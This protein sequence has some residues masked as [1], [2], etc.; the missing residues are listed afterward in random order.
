MAGKLRSGLLGAG[1]LASVSASGITLVWYFTLS[2]LA[3]VEDLPGDRVLRDLHDA[4]PISTVTLQDGLRSR[5]NANHWMFSPNRALD[6]GILNLEIARRIQPGQWEQSNAPQAAIEGFIAALRATPLS[7]YAWNGLMIAETGLGE[8]A[9]RIERLFQLS[10][11]NA[12]VEE[13]LGISRVAFGLTNEHWLSRETK[14]LTRRQIRLAAMMKPDQLFTLVDRINRRE[15]TA[16]YL[17][18]IGG[19]DEL[20]NKLRALP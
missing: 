6:I 4:I 16:D 3:A 2:F 7:S 15:E 9:E 12:P 1:Y 17:E 19:H 10:V 18:A 8:P 20:V 14:D 11:I 5:E 13:R